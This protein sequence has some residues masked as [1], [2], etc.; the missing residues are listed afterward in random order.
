MGYL[1]NAGLARV[2]S[3]IKAAYQ[4]YADSAVRTSEAAVRT[5]IDE[6]VK[7]V[8]EKIVT[9]SGAA[10]A[11][12][13][14]SPSPWGEYDDYTYKLEYTGAF[15]AGA[16]TGTNE[17]LILAPPRGFAF[18]AL[19]Y[20]YTPYIKVSGSATTIAGSLNTNGTFTFTIPKALKGKTF[21]FSTYDNLSFSWLCIEVA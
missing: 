13:K 1:D 21:S 4:A 12:I 2:W 10:S 8:R 18:N 20:S 7:S 6:Q 19:V 5:Y 17:T 15:T 14:V 9:L 16:F 11:S 3:R